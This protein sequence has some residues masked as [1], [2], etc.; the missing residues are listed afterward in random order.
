MRLRKEGF[1]LDFAGGLTEEVWRIAEDRGAS[2][3]SG[4]RGRYVEDDHLPLLMAGIPAIALVDIDFPEWHTLDDRPGACDPAS[5][6]E[7]G[8][9]VLEWLARRSPDA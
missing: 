4:A 1:G 8:R 3:F 7:V 5:I 6:A 2:R 9:V